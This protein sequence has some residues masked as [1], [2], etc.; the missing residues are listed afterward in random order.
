MNCKQGQLLDSG[1]SKLSE[2]TKSVQLP[3]GDSDMTQVKGV[4]VAEACCLGWSN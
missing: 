2:D 1:N 3:K 4:C